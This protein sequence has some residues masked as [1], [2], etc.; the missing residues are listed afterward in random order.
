MKNTI[1]HPY[2]GQKYLSYP[3]IETWLT[4]LAEHFPNWI[5]LTSIGRSRLDRELH[6]VTLGQ[7][8]NRVDERP[9]FWLDGGT[10]SAEWTGIMACIYSLSKWIER[11][12][13]GDEA[14]TEWLKRHT[15][16]VMPCVSPDGFSA[17]YEGQPF[18]RSCMRPPASG[19]IRSGLDPQDV[20]GDGEVRWMRWKHPAGSYVKDEAIPGFMRPR[21]LNDSPEDA[22]FFAPE[23]AF[24]AWDGVAWQQAPRQFGLD[25]NR[26]FPSHWAPFSMFGMDGGVFSLSEPESRALID[27][28]V[29]RPFI[30][31]GLTNHTYTGCILTQ[32]SREN[33]P[34]GDA[35]ILLLERLAHELVEGTDYRVFR[36]FPDFAYNKKKAVVGLWSDTMTTTLGVPSY[37]L[38]LWDPF[39]FCGLENDDPVGFFVKPNHDN[40][41]SLVA[42]MIE[43][44]DAMAPWKSFN[45][46]QL[47]PIEIGGLNYLKTVRNP[48]DEHLAAE[49]ERGFMVA[50]RLRKTLP[51]VNIATEVAT[52]G[53]RKT[54]RVQVENTGYLSTM[55]LDLASSLPGTPYVSVTLEAGDG[56][57]T[58]AGPNA[59]NLPH[60]SGWGLQGTN[61]A[62]SIYPSLTP[63]S[64]RQQVEFDVEGKG[65]VTL[66][67]TL[68]RAGR[69]TL[70]IDVD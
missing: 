70:I 29:A 48:P 69:E 6:L 42:G 36:I 5:K 18:L 15:I 60:L 55:G 11:I 31:A 27:A 8:D 1:W 26:N 20:D 44:T 39:K 35:D 51:S 49:C 21:T 46:P 50:D 32:P 33:S 65:Q 67:F 23:G 14:L 16:Y 45:H 58:I 56:V 7:Q 61:G 68:G 40:I 52:N 19:R 37:T 57:H 13:N 63:K 4:S 54:I 9:G 2:D 10:H 28:F 59:K 43:R 53:T 38:E 62:N 66:T 17:M 25:L 47:G 12:H 30:G 41:R 34:L 22:Y 3:E 24:M 64:H